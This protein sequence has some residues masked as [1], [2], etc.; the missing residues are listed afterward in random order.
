[1][2]YIVLSGWNLNSP[3]VNVQVSETTLSYALCNNII[4]IHTLLVA[5]PYNLMYP[6]DGPPCQT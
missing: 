4:M 3:H 1:M 5:L 6:L 2:E